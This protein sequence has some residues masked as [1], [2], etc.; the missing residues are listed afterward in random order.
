MSKSSIFK[1]NSRF[2]VLSEPNFNEEKKKE[3]QSDKTRSS[4]VTNDKPKMNNFKVDKQLLDTEKPTY[5]ERP[6]YTERPMYN[7]ESNLFSQKVVDKAYKQRKENELNNI[8]NE[9]NKTLSMD[10]FPELKVTNKKSNENTQKPTLIN[11]SEKLKPLVTD[12]ETLEIKQIP[13]GWAVIKRDKTTNKSVIEYNKDYENDIRKSE[14]AKSKNWPMKVLD[15]LVDLH[16]TER[17]KYINKW[18]YDAYEEKYL[19]PDYDDEYFDKLDLE[20]AN[21]TEEEY[22]SETEEEDYIEQNKYYWKY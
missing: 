20:Y 1:T 14:K 18:G 15:A 2:A 12:E 8:N 5:N 21:E 3:K 7:N 17:D 16:E 19:D 22:T 4:L 6:V 10:N 13:Y 11:F 9:I